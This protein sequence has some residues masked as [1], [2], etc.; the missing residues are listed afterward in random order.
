M[1]WVPCQ[2][3]ALLPTAWRCIAIRWASLERI[4]FSFPKI[5]FFFGKTDFN[6]CF[7]LNPTFEDL[8]PLLQPTAK[9]RSRLH[10]ITGPNMGGK[11]TYIRLPGGTGGTGGTGPERGEKNGASRGLAMPRNASR[12]IALIALLN[13]MGSFVPCR[14]A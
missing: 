10:L 6:E 14:A 7:N 11:S 2:G 5:V 9:R 3:K 4:F 13:Q 8:R 1:D 12:S